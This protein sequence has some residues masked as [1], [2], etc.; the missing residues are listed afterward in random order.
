MSGFGK[1]YEEQQAEES[2][3]GGSSWLLNMEEGI[4][5]NF[6]A[7]DFRANLEGLSFENMKQ[8][9]EAQ[10]PKKILGMGYQQR[11]KVNYLD[12]KRAHHFWRILGSFGTLLT[13]RTPSGELTSKRMED[14]LLPGLIY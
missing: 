9:M 4:P 12:F 11:F 14:D 8:S 6:E 13:A 10:M 3:S 1:W 5:L 2:G 7:V